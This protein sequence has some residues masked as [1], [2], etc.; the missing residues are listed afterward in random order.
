MKLRLSKALALLLCL[1]LWIC[2]LPAAFAADEPAGP[3]WGNSA[4]QAYQPQE[5]PTL[6]AREDNA[7]EAATDIYAELTAAIKAGQ[8]GIDM[9][10]KAF[11]ISKSIEIPENFTVHFYLGGS[12]TIPKGVTLTVRG[13]V[14]GSSITLGGTV[15][16]Y[17]VVKAGDGITL[18]SA[19]LFRFHDSSSLT[20][21][22][23]DPLDSRFSY[24][25]VD[26][27]FEVQMDVD[28]QE[29]LLQ[30]KTKFE[31]APDAVYG[32]IHISFPWTLDQD[33]TFTD[34]VGLEVHGNEKEAWVRVPRGV[35]L[36]VQRARLQ[37][38][39]M[40]V[41]GTLINNQEL[42]LDS[43][44]RAPVGPTGS[45][46][47]EGGIYSGDGKITIRGI[48][49][50][51]S[52]LVGLDLNRFTRYYESDAFAYYPRE[53]GMSFADIV[54]LSKTP[55]TYD[56]TNPGRFTF[57]RDFTV[58][59]GVWFN[60]FSGEL[61]IPR[62]VT[63]TVN[64][65]MN[66]SR[67]VVDGRLVTNGWVGVHDVFDFDGD[68]NRLSINSGIEITDKVWDDALYSLRMTEG[69]MLSVMAVANNDEEM[70]QILGIHYNFPNEHFER[71]VYQ[72][73]QRTLYGTL[74]VPKYY[75]YQIPGHWSQYSD[76]NHPDLIVRPGAT[77][78]IE[79]EI[80]CK[81][82]VI[83][84]YG[85][86]ENEGVLHLHNDRRNVTHLSFAN[87]GSYSGSGEI[88]ALN[89]PDPDGMLSGLN[90]NDFEILRKPEGATYALRN[91]GTEAENIYEELAAMIAEGRKELDFSKRGSLT[92]PESGS[93]VIPAGTIA[94]F[95]GAHLTIPEGFNLIVEGELGDLILGEVQLDGRITSRNGGRASIQDKLDRG[96]NG[97]IYVNN[98]VSNF[99]IEA[100]GLPDD[101]L[102]VIQGDSRVNY[103]DW[104]VRSYND[105]YAL[106]DYVAPDERIAAAA[107][108][109]FNMTVDSDL[110]IYTRN[111]L[112]SLAVS[113]RVNGYLTVAEGATLTMETFFSVDQGADLQVYGTLVNNY[114]LEIKDDSSVSLLGGRARYTG[115][116]IITVK[117]IA[118]PES[119]LHGF[120]MKRFVHNDRSDRIIYMFPEPDFRLPSSLKTIG[121]EAF[122]GGAFRYPLLPDGVTS[123]G[124]R[125]FADC[126]NLSYIYIPASVKSIDSTA[127]AGVSDLN[128]LGAAGSYAERFAAKYGFHFIAD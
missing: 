69:A 121:A 56:I 68:V 33:V 47:V 75:K 125:A 23:A 15:E 5:A 74:E 73:Y 43:S 97:H 8:E 116:G 119:H 9:D 62:G 106:M 71:G 16:N 32:N 79:G 91:S 7:F 105:L 127:F 113:P 11:R 44:T 36:E 94:R 48:D 92:L 17:G 42:T 37:C 104:R 118:N 84:V 108:I 40:I 53:G 20:T 6:S 77:V 31:N 39:D 30:A 82:A 128:I 35:T 114:N 111:S 19:A 89:T 72:A 49:N 87:N 14:E 101:A 83:T 2:A 13:R 3:G 60:A 78:H 55:G 65:A 54:E 124:K 27:D 99:N 126:P 57:E 115:S 85:S 109:A 21:F 22:G 66:I 61:Y 100:N 4:D 88:W 29:Q 34:K 122:C 81:D 90:L 123:I 46:R 86:V 110:T 58:P 107:V 95:Q 26:C 117:D 120:D 80:L 59:E 51:D 45:L 102:Y 70:E 1:A 112:F 52:R 25:N 10:G 93:I 63:L 76:Y 103:Y 41:E 96:R 98:A 12:L 24:A 28:S 18:G 38:A 50:G 67:L 64:G